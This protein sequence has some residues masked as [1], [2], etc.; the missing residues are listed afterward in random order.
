MTKDEIS[1]LSWKFSQQLFADIS[2]FEAELRSANDQIAEEDW[3]PQEVA[4]NFEQLL[5]QYMCN[6]SSPS[7]LLDNEFLSQEDRNTFEEY[8]DQELHQVDVFAK[9]TA[10]N[11][12]YFTIVELLFKAHNQLANKQLGDHVFFEEIGLEPNKVDGLPVFYISAGS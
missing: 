5:L 9:I 1:G 8:P 6:V 3:H 2:S 4:A 11:N 10:D 12:A 7:D